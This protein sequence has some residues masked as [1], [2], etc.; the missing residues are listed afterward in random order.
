ME[1]QIDVGGIA[2]ILMAIV[3][4]Y[5]AIKKR[6]PEKATTAATYQSIAFKQAKESKVLRADNK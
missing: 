1:W 5:V 2:A 6:I 3:S 4:L